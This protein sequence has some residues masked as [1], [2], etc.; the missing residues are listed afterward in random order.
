MSN[1]SSLLYG[2]DMGDKKAK[3][4]IQKKPGN[5]RDRQATEFG[6]WILFGS[7]SG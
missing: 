2:K 5:E 6:P 4:K 3:G 1:Y 7:A